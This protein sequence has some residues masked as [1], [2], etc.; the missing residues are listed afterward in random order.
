MVGGQSNTD[1]TDQTTSQ[2]EVFA[3]AI[4]PRKSSRLNL[5]TL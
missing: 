2:F 1:N 5:Y 4:F 3:Q